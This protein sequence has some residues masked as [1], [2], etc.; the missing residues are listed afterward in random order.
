M[1]GGLG[2]SRRQRLLKAAEFEA[3]FAHRCNVRT[4][5]FQ[6]MAMPNGLGY[7]RLGMI[8]AKRHFPRAVDR[9]HVR[10][11]IRETFRQLAESLPALDLV[12][13]PQ[14]GTANGGPEADRSQDLSSAFSKAAKKCSPVC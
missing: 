9:N 4:A 11:Q 6:V 3:V 2:F 7:S 13:R 14:E 5:F 12:V 10:R 1:S 8:V